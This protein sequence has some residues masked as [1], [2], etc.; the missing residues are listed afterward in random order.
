M[1]MA[2][3]EM[4]SSKLT[5]SQKSGKNKARDHRTTCLGRMYDC[6][7]LESELVELHLDI[8]HPEMNKQPTNKKPR[9]DTKNKCAI[10]ILDAQI[11]LMLKNQ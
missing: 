10:F 2:T 7:S 6:T 4:K 5:K 1:I 9:P 8:Y 3:N 11:H